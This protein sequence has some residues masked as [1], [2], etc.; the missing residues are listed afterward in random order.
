MTDFINFDEVITKIYG[1]KK[2][3]DQQDFN[4]PDHPF[5]MCIIG[6]SGSGKTNTLVNMLFK[7]LKFEKIYLYAHDLTEDKYVFLIDHMKNLEKEYSKKTGK[8]IKLIEYSNKIKDVVDPDKMDTKLR[9]VIIFDDM[10][11]E[12]D[13]SKI[14]EL[15]IRGRKK[16]ASIIYLSQSYFKIPKTIRIN[17]TYFILNKIPT[18]KELRQIAD[19]HAVGI[20]FKKFKEIY[21]G[22][23]EGPHDFFLLDKVSTELPMKYRKNFDGLFT[24]T[25]EEIKSKKPEKVKPELTGDG[26]TD[27][28]AWLEELNGQMEELKKEI[29]RCKLIIRGN[30]TKNKKNIS[31]DSSDEV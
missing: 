31:D 5:R 22:A 23:T 10:V 28:N 3:Y 24:G 29:K 13:Q 20:D 16:N 12:K 26:I 6:G 18:N 11:L 2:K 27:Y 7:M 15:F 17:S 4:A 1:E 21:E 30:K 9:S 25:L 14:E 8:E 19:D